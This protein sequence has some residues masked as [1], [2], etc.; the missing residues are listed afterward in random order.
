MPA[1]ELTWNS[2]VDVRIF[3]VKSSIQTLFVELPNHKLAPLVE[4]A[5]D[6]RSLRV[7]RGSAGAIGRLLPTVPAQR[8]I[9]WCSRQHHMLP[10]FYQSC[11]EQRRMAFSSR[12]A[13]SR[14]PPSGARGREQCQR[15]GW[16]CRTC[17]GVS[18]E[19]T[20][21]WVSAS[22]QD[23]CD[24]RAGK[25]AHR[26]LPRLR[27]LLNASCPGV[28]MMRRPGTLTSIMPYLLQC[29]NSC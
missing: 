21:A 25:G 7:E 12:A 4:F 17:G 18:A 28:S 8:W 2:L 19:R 27:K 16:R 10:T 14:T 22:V 23:D 3:P 5:L 13:C 20:N 11:L 1:E 9:H 29:I 24:V 26:E 6:I 15:R